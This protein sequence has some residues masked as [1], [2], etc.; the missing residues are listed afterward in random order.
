MERSAVSEFGERLLARSAA[1]AR[2]GPAMPVTRY[3][4]DVTDAEWRT[5]A[6]HLP[7]PCATGWRSLP[8]HLPPL[9][10]DLPL[11]RCLARRRAL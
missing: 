3:Q 9:A 6:P 8:G 7:K 2:T 11:V 10:D 1:Q 4:T 5:I